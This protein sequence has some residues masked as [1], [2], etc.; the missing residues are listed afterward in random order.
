MIKENKPTIVRKVI[1][2]D[3]SNKVRYALESV[4]AR[5]TGHN[6]YIAGYRVG[7]KTGTA[8][9]AVNGAY[10]SGNYITSFIGFLPAD[11]PELVI[12][13]AVDNAKGITQYGGTVA[14]PM[15]KNFM[16]SAIDI[17]NIEKRENEL[18]REY[19]YTDK[20]YSL[21]PN[22]IGMNVKDAIKELKKFKVEYSGS[23]ENITYQSPSS[24]EFIYEGETI[25]L[26][27]SE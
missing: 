9:K 6:A 23:G 12:Y 17:L 25:R 1:S 22:V 20:Q 14:A 5:G 15:A 3:T 10:L 18:E 16:L 11:K 26:L 7:G 21:V 24:G 4:V 2:E 13:I 27:L 19:L 8:Q